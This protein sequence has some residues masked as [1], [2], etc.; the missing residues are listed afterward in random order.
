[1]GWW[2]PGLLVQWLANCCLAA[3]A[4]RK[5]ALILKVE[6]YALDPSP[7]YVARCNVGGSRGVLSLSPDVNERQEA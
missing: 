6:K 4:M 2:A 7:T 5:S 3:P 1:M